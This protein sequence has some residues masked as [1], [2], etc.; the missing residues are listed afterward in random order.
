MG[1]QQLHYGMTIEVEGIFELADSSS[2]A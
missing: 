1:M 2:S